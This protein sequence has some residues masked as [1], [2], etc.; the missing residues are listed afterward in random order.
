MNA[1][2]LKK[3]IEPTHLEDEDQTEHLKKVLEEK[4][5]K[6][7]QDEDE[8]KADDPKSE[9]EYSFDFQ[10][11]DV[12]GKTWMGKFT[13]KILNERERRQVGIMRSML[14][15]GQPYESLDMLTRD[16]ALIH[17][18]L[19][20]SLTQKPKWAEKLDEIHDRRVVEAIYEEVMAHEAHFLGYDRDSSQSQANS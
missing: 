2:E 10:Y 6:L 12:H 17:A 1:E 9:V 13:N 20:H 4:T 15:A 18:H 19:A 8:M 7:E 3:R 16:N 5:K 14:T 11:R